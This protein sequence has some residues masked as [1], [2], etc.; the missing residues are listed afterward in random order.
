MTIHDFRGISTARYDVPD[1]KAQMARLRER[2]ALLTGPTNAR[3]RQ[4]LRRKLRRLTVRRTYT[5][6]FGSALAHRSTRTMPATVLTGLQPADR[7]LLAS[8]A[9]PRLR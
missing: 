9:R 7:F 1:T 3:R 6:G 4:R 5:I 8:P 2:L